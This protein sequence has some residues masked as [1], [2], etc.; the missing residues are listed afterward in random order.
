MKNRAVA[1]VFQEIAD[2][3]EI[4]GENPFKIRAYRKAA[5]TIEN[6]STDLKTLMEENKLREVPGIGEA[7]AKKI[8][9]LLTTGHLGYY[10]ELRRE[11]PEGTLSLMSIPG[12]GPKTAIRLAKELGISNIDE[13]EKAIINGRVSGLYR[14]GDKVAANIL[15]HIRMS[16][17]KDMRIPIGE[18]LPVVEQIVALLRDRPGLQHLVP[19]G[20][21]RRFKET[22][23]DIDIMGTADKPQDVLQAFVELPLVEEILAKGAS[24]ASVITTGGIQVDLRMVEPDCFGSLLQYFTGSKEH[25]IILRERALRQGLSLSEYG[26]TVLETRKTEKFATEEAF[27]DRLG[28]Q[29]VPP[30]LREGRHEIELAEK[31]AIPRLIETSDIKGDLHVH[32]NWSDGFDS[33]EA[34][35]EAAMSRGYAYLAVTDHS[36]G[37]GIAHGLSEERLKKQITEIRALNPKLRGLRLLCGVEVDI[38]SDGT[39]DLPDDI[40]RE[41]DVVIAGVHS[42]MAQDSEKMTRRLVLALENPYVHIL[43]HPTCRLLGVREP[44]DVDLEAVLHTAARTGTA[45]EIN[46]TP[47]RLDLNDLHVMRARELGVKLVIGTD[48]HSAPQLDTIRFGVGVARRGWCGKSDIFNTKPVDEVLTLFKRKARASQRTVA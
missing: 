28:L 42:A 29:Y 2:L 44:V 15:R 38:R 11:F 1:R 43:A 47:Q 9:E 14:L 6:L 3:L 35:A 20:S 39:L 32:T 36:A 13:L 26:I 5:H 34:M 8:T 31:R 22:I 24:K 30:E 21:L 18:A 16:R 40:L 25:N 27:Y 48:A 33:I 45:L 37:R 23:G 41:L 12:I 46:A 10:E 19:A 7:I 17:H 4:K